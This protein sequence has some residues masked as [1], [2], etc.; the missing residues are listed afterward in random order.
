MVSY[1]KLLNKSNT[2]TYL[3]KCVHVH[4]LVH[5]TVSHPLVRLVGG[6]TASEGRVE[7]YYSSTWGTVCQTHWGIQDATVVCRELGYP[8]ALAA[9]GYSTFGGGTGQVLYSSE[10]NGTCGM[11][12]NLWNEIDYSHL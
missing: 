9:P 12:L 6:N 11:E 8:R 5:N 2:Y 7:V 10:W 3:H 4:T 1:S